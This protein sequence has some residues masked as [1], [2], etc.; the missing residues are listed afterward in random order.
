MLV[1]ED[2]QWADKGSLLLLRHLI[3]A[4]QDM[5]VLVF[6]TY[7]DSELSRTHPLVE[8]LAALHRQSGVS[9]IE[10]TG[11]DDTGVLSLMEAAAGQ[12]MDDAG[13]DLAHAV[14]QRDGRQPILRERGTATPLR[15]RR[16]LPGRRRTVD[17]TRSSPS[18]SL[19][20]KV[21]AW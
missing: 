5:R 11:L 2:L 12:A 6:A 10:L 3:A 7:R 21:S 14:H 20:P 13:V 16:H 18:R 1:F 15:D 4:E 17:G 8:T 19:C 9:R